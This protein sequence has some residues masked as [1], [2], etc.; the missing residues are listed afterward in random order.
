MNTVSAARR[1]WPIFRMCRLLVDGN[2][3][4][5][6]SGSRSDGAESWSL[7]LVWALIPYQMSTWKLAIS[8]LTPLA[9]SPADDTRRYPA[10]IPL[11]R[12]S[13]RIGA[14]SD[15]TTC[16]PVSPLGQ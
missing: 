16:T 13:G 3:L 8:G 5:G 6:S 11:S 7:A 12:W 10:P 15:T 14:V 4:D 1:I 9:E 2:L